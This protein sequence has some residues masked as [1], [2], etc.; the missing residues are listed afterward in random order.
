MSYLC[1]LRGIWR[2]GQPYPLAVG[3]QQ[4]LIEFLLEA[5]E[6]Q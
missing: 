5:F 1:I 6:D 3:A 4:V 2:H